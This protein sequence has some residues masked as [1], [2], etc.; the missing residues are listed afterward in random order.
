MLVCSICSASYADD[1]PRWRCD[2]GGYLMLRDSA[3]FLRESL[4]DRPATLWRYFEALGIRD[5][6]NVVSLAEGHT[7]L[8]PA[9]LDGTPAMFKL[10]YLCPTGSYKDRGSTVMMSKLKE[11]GV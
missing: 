4:P 1:Q 11:W 5:Q 7:P 3:M 8:V 9:R 10:D 2:C 6:S